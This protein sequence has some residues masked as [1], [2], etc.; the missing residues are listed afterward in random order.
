MWDKL[1]LHNMFS[2][3][4]IT[5]LICIITLIDWIFNPNKRFDIDSACYS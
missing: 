5:S 3:N 1:E 4:N 2:I